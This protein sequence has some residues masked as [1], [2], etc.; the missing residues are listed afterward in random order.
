MQG[1]GMGMSA[2]LGFASARPGAVGFGGRWEGMEVGDAGWWGVGNSP[3]K[4]VP[5]GTKWSGAWR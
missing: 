3:C 2:G 4:R 1:V 5:M